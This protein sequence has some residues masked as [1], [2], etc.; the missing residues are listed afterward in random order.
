MV[1]G[2]WPLNPEVINDKL[3]PNEV[4]KDTSKQPNHKL[5]AC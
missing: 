1:T 4:S 2:I 5:E 3:L